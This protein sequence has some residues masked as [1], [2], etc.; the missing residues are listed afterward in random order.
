MVWSRLISNG[1][2]CWRL[3]VAAAVLCVAV[4]VPLAASAQSSAAALPSFEELEASGATIGSI[5]V[6][7]RD[8]FDTEDP[9]EDKLPFRLANAL[10]IRTR[11]SVV[12][13]ALLFKSGDPVSVRVIDETERLLRGARFLYDVQLRPIAYRDGV[14]DI[15]VTTRDTWTLDLGLSAGRSGGANTSGVSLQEYNLLGSGIA[16]GYSRSNDVDRSSNEFEISTDRAF[17]GW[18]SLSYSRSQNSDGAREAASVQRPFYA[19]DTRWAGGFTLSRDDR[20]D[21]V[22]NAGTVVGQYRH[23]REFAEVFGGWSQGRVDGW[24]RRYSIGL[25]HKDNVYSLEPGRVAPARLPRN[26]KLVAPFVRFELIEDR[27]EKMRNLNQV[28]RPEFLS[29]GWSSTLQL[30]RATKALGSTRDAWL[31]AGSIGRGFEPAPGHRLITSATISGQYADG[32]VLRQRLG[33]VA[34][35]YLRQDARWL[36][37]GALSADALTNADPA[38]ELLL[39]GDNGLRGYPLRYQ[40]G[41]R[42]VLVTLE[43]R[44]YTDLYLLRLFRV[45]GAAFVDVGR[46]WGGDNV[47]A[48]NPGW[49][50][51]IGFGLRFFSVRSALGN[52]L[53]LDLAYPLRPGAD[54]KRVQFLVKTKSS[55]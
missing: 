39:G 45:G 25:T 31:Y 29:L 7:T 17:D 26:E 18:T 27:F 51:N 22:Y 4:T 41:Q 49:L 54:I 11:A 34:R 16:V 1:V 2:R 55:F 20:I 53:H 37:Y 33:G 46:A 47:N 44:A 36:F 14:V 30:G 12:E 21:A 13:R 32:K 24:V 35:Y 15:E 43:E 19:L 42:R 48:A 40:S 23:S 6:V 5:S 50:G 9:K 10:H 38:D 28:D 3:S 52:V 8:I